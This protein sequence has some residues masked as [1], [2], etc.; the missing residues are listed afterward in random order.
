MSEYRIVPSEWG[1]LVDKA[2][3]SMGRLFQNDYIPLD[4]K[5]YCEILEES[6]K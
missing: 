3:Q 5:D 1:D 6:Y 2:M 4:K